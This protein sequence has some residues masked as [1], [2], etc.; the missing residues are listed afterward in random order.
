MSL[1]ILKDEI[2]N[3]ILRRCYLF[4]GEEQFVA[5]Y[6]EQRLDVLIYG[7]NKVESGFKDVFDASVQTKDI[8]MACDTLPFFTEKRLVV[9]KD[10]G[11]F[12][13]E[14]KSE[15]ELLCDYIASVP[16]E[17]VLVFRE[18]NV[19]KRLKLYKEIVK[20]GMVVDFTKLAHG[21]LLKWIQR[22]AKDHKKSISTEAAAML[23]RYVGSDMHTISHEIEKLAAA[24]QSQDIST[25]EISALSPQKLES[26]IFELTKAMGSGN[27]KEALKQYHNMLANKEY[28][29]MILIMIVR[30][31]R[32]ILMVKTAIE[33]GMNKYQ[34]CQK[35]GLRDFMVL[36]AEMQAKRFTQN[37]LIEAL[38]YCLE[39]DVKS[40]TGFISPEIGVEMVI[41]RY[42]M[43]NEN[44]I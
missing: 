30:Q 10:S 13:A 24:S 25:I 17:T 2:K 26:R 28:P 3:K 14:R 21:D 18:K 29:G 15:A 8:I 27:V 16:M 37:Q 9:V 5:E 32:I 41:V 19:D 38:E 6:Y 20:C 44:N 7:T 31:L 33:Q 12:S 40:K 43:R 39:I 36:E 23:M 11:L 4:F 42:G 22:I 35:L 1:N 34:I